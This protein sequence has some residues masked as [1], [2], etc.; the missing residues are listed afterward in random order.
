MNGEPPAA[1][2]QVP[3]APGVPAIAAPAEVPADPAVAEPAPIETF[4]LS[5]SQLRARD[6]EHRRDALDR[7][8]AKVVSV[9][10][11]STGER[12]ITLDNGQVWLQTEATVRGPLREGDAVVIRRAALG[13]FQIV[14]PGRVAL[15]VRRIE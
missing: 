3:V 12:L 4:G 8:E 11:R 10:H 13:S 9:Q 5:E 14:T 6:P 15:R 7:I 2:S 1:R